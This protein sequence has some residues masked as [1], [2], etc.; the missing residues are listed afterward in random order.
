MTA[1]DNK[2]RKLRIKIIVR[3]RQRMSRDG[4]NEWGHPLKAMISKSKLTWHHYAN[5]PDKFQDPEEPYQ[6]NGKKNITVPTEL[7]ATD[8]AV[9]NFI[10][11]N[12]SVSD[13]DILALQGFSHA[14]TKTHVAF[15]SHLFEIRITNVEQR[16]AEVI[17]LH[18][19]N[20]R[21]WRREA[22]K[23]RR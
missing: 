23:V 14:K 5:P 16:K 11:D 10:F 18:H 6:P 8:V 2:G 22:R 20:N 12:F 1:L 19:V 3:K 15:S 7:L 9:R 4:F 17:P 13:G 21:W